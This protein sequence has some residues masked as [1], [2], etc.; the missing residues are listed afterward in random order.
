[1]NIHDE[2]QFEIWKGE[3]HLIQKILDIMQSHDWHQVP[4]VSDV[5][6]AEENW[7]TK[8]DWEGAA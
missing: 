7:A 6:I 4:I 2:L 1:M 8:K 3:E 5:E